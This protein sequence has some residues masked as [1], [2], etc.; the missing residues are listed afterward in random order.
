MRVK[1][2]A[3]RFFYGQFAA[4][5]PDFWLLLCAAFKPAIAVFSGVTP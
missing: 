2:L 4:L 5:H 1:T 3:G